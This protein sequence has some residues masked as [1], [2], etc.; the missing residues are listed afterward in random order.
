[1]ATLPTWAGRSKFRY[2]GSVKEGVRI[3]YGKGFSFTQHITAQEFRD[4][5]TNFRGRKINIGTSRTA[6]PPGS[7]GQWLKANV[8][9]TAIA[10]YV[11][12]IL[13][14][15]NYASKV[16]G[17]MIQF[18][19]EIRETTKAEQETLVQRMKADEITDRERRKYERFRV[20]APVGLTI[21]GVN[22]S[23][24]TVDASKEGMLVE[25][26]LSPEEALKLLKVLNKTPNY[27]LEVEYLYEEERYV[28]EAEIT[29]FQLI[30]PGGKPYRFMVGFWI[31]KI[32]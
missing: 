6:P 14:K 12:P 11:G 25:F 32:K 27:R 1:M 24:F 16:G 9:K 15:E 22:L 21:G 2:E 8:T 7:V 3:K 26:Y 29:H 31:P 28:R 20:K 4:L 17:P 5:L 18:F 23:G 19:P 30:F 10:S 13:V